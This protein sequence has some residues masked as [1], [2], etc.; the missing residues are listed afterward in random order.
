MCRNVQFARKNKY[1]ALSWGFA[2][3]V[4]LSSRLGNFVHLNL[5]PCKGLKQVLHVTYCLDLPSP[6]TIHVSQ[7]CKALGDNCVV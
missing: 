5:Q 1:M 7:L 6:A 3:A 2:T 4:M